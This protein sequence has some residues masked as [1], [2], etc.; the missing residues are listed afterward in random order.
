MKY[1]IIINFNKF[2]LNTTY[3]ILILHLPI[4]KEYK[5]VETIDQYVDQISVAYEKTIIF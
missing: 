2:K 4:Y 1:N 3:I 5:T